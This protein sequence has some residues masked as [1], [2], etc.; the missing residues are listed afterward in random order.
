ML[1]LGILVSSLN[2]MH[3]IFCSVQP[4][5]LLRHHGLRFITSSV[6][7]KAAEQKAAM[8][9]EVREKEA[10]EK[11]AAEESAGEEISQVGEP[12]DSLPTAEASSI[13]KKA[14]AEKWTSRFS[15]MKRSKTPT[16]STAYQLGSTPCKVVL[17]DDTDDVCMEC[18]S[19]LE[20][21]D[22]CATT[23]AATTTPAGN[24]ETKPTDAQ[25][26]RS[27]PCEWFICDDELAKIRNFVIQVSTKIFINLSVIACGLSLWTN[28]LLV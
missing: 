4:G 13:T 7:I 10:R 1:V 23:P 5:D 18:K 15:F 9:K 27:C 21:P 19:K 28:I 2:L 24:E 6:H 25:S 22:G 11:A 20:I 14:D 26:S 17:A 3:F 16:E 12:H 8:E